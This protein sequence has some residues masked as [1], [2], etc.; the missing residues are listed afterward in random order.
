[1][2]ALATAEKALAAHAGRF[3]MVQGDVTDAAAMDGL[4]EE[5]EKEVGPLKG[6]VTSAGIGRD[7]PFLETTAEM[8]RLI[9]EI[10]VVGT[11]NIARAAAAAMRASGGGAIVT[12]A[13]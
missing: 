6:L 5:T 8:F 10:N 7:V 12:I 13:S 2:G 11:F 4:V 3:R 1:P 9:H